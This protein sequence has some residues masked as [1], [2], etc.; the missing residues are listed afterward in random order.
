MSYLYD[1]EPDDDYEYPQ[2]EPGIHYVK[3]AVVK[4][5][6]SQKGNQ[7]IEV[8]LHSKEGARVFYNIV[9][10]QWFNKNLT[11][12]LDCFKI[13]RNNLNLARWEG[14]YGHIEVGLG[15]QRENGKTYMEVKKLIVNKEGNQPQRQPEQPKPSAPAD[16]GFDDDILF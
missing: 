1:Y 2:F 6:T 11:R 10:G 3:I 8:E 5:K 9:E 4:E 13:P 14:S 12:F 15:T 16:D 7:M